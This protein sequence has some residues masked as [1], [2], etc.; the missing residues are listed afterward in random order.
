MALSDRR[1]RFPSALALAVA[2]LLAV[3]GAGAAQT[4]LEAYH[5][6]LDAVERGD[7]PT[8]ERLMTEATAERPEAAQRLIRHLQFK[9][10]VPWFYLGLARYHRAT[11]RA[12]SKPGP[13]PSA[14]AWRRPSQR[15]GRRC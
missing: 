8:A 14:R 10:Y 5:A 6:G 13:S 7:W 4:F 12:L 11:A 2:L 15:A 9:P 3:P 1:G